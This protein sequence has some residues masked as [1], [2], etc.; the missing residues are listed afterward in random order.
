MG[1]NAVVHFQVNHQGATSAKYAKE[2][3]V[4]REPGVATDRLAT[5]VI[6]AAMEVHRTMGVGF[7][8]SVL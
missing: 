7:I 5:A 6:D 8:E 2:P 4:M 1:R 3:V